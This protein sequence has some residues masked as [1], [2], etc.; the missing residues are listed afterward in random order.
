MATFAER[1]RE[2]RKEKGLNQSELA[3]AIHTTLGTVSIWERGVREPEKSTL[4]K[5][6]EFFDVSLSYLWGESDDRHEPLRTEDHDE[7]SKSK[8]DDLL[9]DMVLYSLLGDES[10][11]VVSSMIR[12]LYEADQARKLLVEPSDGL[13]EELEKMF[14]QDFLR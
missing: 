1:L 10:K 5:L 4:K 9:S 12:L 13:R 14:H 3:E 2:L 6:C 11:S 8:H 7:Y